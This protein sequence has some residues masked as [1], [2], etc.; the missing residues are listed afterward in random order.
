[1]KPILNKGLWIALG[2][3][4]SLILIIQSCKK[5]ESHPNIPNVYVNLY[6]DINSTQ[7]IELNSVGGYVYLTGGYRG[8]LVYRVSVEDFIAF[9]RTC[10]YD[11]D[12][13]CARI[14]ME[15]SGLTTV[16]SCCMSRYLIL[17]GS[18]LRGPSTIP[19]KQY[20]TSFDGNILH[21]Y[22]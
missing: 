21:I 1:M 16:D 19:L 12:K 20:R 5:N 22:N 3:F 10:P 8:I 7:Y 18:V 17:D 4:L 6:L 14:E 2:L 13:D 15:P 11:P 9:E